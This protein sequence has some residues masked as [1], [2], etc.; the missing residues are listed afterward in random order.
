MIFVETIPITLSIIF[1]VSVSGAIFALRY[2]ILRKKS[3]EALYALPSVLVTGPKK[4][5]KSSIIKLMTNEDV[6]THAFKDDIKLCIVGKGKNAV[7]F[8]ELPGLS[9]DITTTAE[10]FLFKRL[11][12]KKLKKFNMK[13]MIYIFDMSKSSEKFD[14]QLED[15]DDIKKT[16]G[17]LPL[18]VIANKLH[19]SE[20]EKLEKL[21]SRFEKVYEISAFKND[22]ITSNTLLQ[23][24]KEFEDVT[25]LIDGLSRDITKEKHLA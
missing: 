13:H 9:D 25:D 1:A 21:K 16:V 18:T 5:G 15:F 3:L 14:N 22:G 20:K 24:R 8:I 17:D 19:D 10:G 4:V 2:G 11:S 7:Q 12:L 6:L 23:L